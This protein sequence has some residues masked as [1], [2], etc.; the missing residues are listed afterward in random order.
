MNEP[1]LKCAFQKF[2]IKS[3]DSSLHY[4]LTFSFVICQIVRSKLE[5]FQIFENRFQISLI[6]CFQKFLFEFESK[7]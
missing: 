4:K 5:F 1:A 2:R 6:K 3:F 7:N